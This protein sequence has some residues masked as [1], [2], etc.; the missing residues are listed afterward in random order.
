VF[1]NVGNEKNQII[2]GPCS[3]SWKAASLWKNMMKDLNFGKAFLNAFGC[4][5]HM[6]KSQ[7][8]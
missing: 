4:K 3:C 7:L 5:K 6:K 8:T 2:Y 1:S